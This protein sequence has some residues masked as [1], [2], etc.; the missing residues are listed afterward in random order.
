MGR[1]NKPNLAK[2]KRILKRAQ[3]SKTCVDVRIA[4]ERQ[5]TRIDFLLDQGG[6][7]KTQYAREVAMLGQMY[8]GAI[9][10]MQGVNGMAANSIKSSFVRHILNSEMY[11][12][13]I[14]TQQRLNKQG[15]SVNL[16][17]RKD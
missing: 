5:V 10:E 16:F 2:R 15:Q 9:R 3:L 8:A 14:K 13:F 1:T 12:H 17:R 7:D 4:F 11:T 6:I